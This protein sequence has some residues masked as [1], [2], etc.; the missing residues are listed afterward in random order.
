MENKNNL[1]NWRNY[2][3]FHY[4]RISILAFVSPT[5]R[6][7]PFMNKPIF[8]Y[9]VYARSTKASFSIW[10]GTERERERKREERDKKMVVVKRSHEKPVTESLTKISARLNLTGGIVLNS[11]GVRTRTLTLQ[12]VN[13]QTRKG[14]LAVELIV[15]AESGARSTDARE[16]ISFLLSILNLQW[17]FISTYTNTFNHVLHRSEN[18]R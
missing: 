3:Y 8:S 5:D 6:L 12:P 1:R 18:S 14:C 4:Y 2:H 13:E 10:G 11:R 16:A 7:F 15:K 9:N 17:K